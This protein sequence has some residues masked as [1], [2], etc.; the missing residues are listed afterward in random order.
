MAD[1]AEQK[2]A[3]LTLFARSIGYRVRREHLDG[4]GGGLATVNGLRWIL[5]DDMQTAEENSRIL[6]GALRDD[7][8][9]LSAGVQPKLQQIVPSEPLRKAA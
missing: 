2:L 8:E 5:L 6:L 1:R 9:S 3:E 4:C 7:T